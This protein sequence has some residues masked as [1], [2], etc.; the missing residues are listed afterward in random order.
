LDLQTQLYHFSSKPPTR[1]VPTKQLEPFRRHEKFVEMEAASALAIAPARIPVAL[2][3]TTDNKIHTCVVSQARDFPQF[4]WTALRSKE[5]DANTILPPLLKCWEM[6]QEGSITL[7]QLW[8]I[9]YTSSQQ[10]EVKLIASC[11]DGPTGS[12]PIFI[13]TPIPTQYIERERTIL[14]LGLNCIVRELLD[15]VHRKRVYSVFALEK[16]SRMFASL[17]TEA[18]R[19]PVMKDPYKEEKISFLTAE[20]FKRNDLPLPPNETCDLRP[21]VRADREQVAK[22]C[23]MYAADSVCLLL[24]SHYTSLTLIL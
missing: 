24:L 5:V 6:E 20:T 10:P 4:A 9:I 7:N 1:Q 8:I 16:L 17:W 3:Q 23:Y 13:F 19:I 11:T 22:L 15:R 2:K 12:Y 18:T 21:A 14:F